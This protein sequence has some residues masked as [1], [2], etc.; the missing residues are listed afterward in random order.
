M[1]IEVPDLARYA[2]IEIPGQYVDSRKLRYI[3]IM[4]GDPMPW[5]VR[6]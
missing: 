1:A 6:R 2:G 4:P 3:I 5:Q